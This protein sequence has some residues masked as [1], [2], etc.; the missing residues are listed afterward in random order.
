MIMSVV[1]CNN[2]CPCVLIFCIIVPMKQ[3]LSFLFLAIL[4]VSSWAQ[5]G[6]DTLKTPV[7]QFSGVVVAGD[8]LAPVPLSAVYRN[9][10]NR[11]TF[12]DFYGFFSIPAFVGDTITFSHIGYTSSSYVIPN[13]LTENRY[14]IVQLL[15]TD[16]VNIPEAF[17]YP[18]PTKEKFKED[19]LALELPDSE[20]EIARKNLDKIILKDKMYEM[21]MD[22]SENYK[23]AMQQV[24]EKLYYAG[25]NPP[26]SVLNPFA[27]A[28]FIKA[29]RDGSLK[30]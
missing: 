23:L 25:Q 15:T 12:T 27:W 10:D 13:D 2:Q 16:T 14:S 29:L 28:A 26:I 24:N 21:S 1:Y 8:S 7:I 17:V 4:A 20:A 30:R 3:L 11:G 18:W 5:E 19:F 22:G 9:R 6:E